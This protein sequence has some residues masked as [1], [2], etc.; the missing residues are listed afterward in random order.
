MRDRRCRLEPAHEAEAEA[1][2]ARID[3]AAAFASGHPVWSYFDE[4]QAAVGHL[5]RL[6]GGD[7]AGGAAGAQIDPDA[8]ADLSGPDA[9]GVH[10]AAAVFEDL[11][12]HDARTVDID[13]LA[14][15][16]VREGSLFA[17]GGVVRL[18]LWWQRGGLW[19]CRRNDG[20]PGKG[21]AC[22]QTGEQKIG[23]SCDHGCDHNM[24][25][26]N[27]SGMLGARRVQG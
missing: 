23:L 27:R 21:E 15:G 3:H 17:R 26:M 1:I 10:R 25:Q 5:K 11:Q 22:R 14:K 24:R 13:A 9:A 19:L 6:A 4:F 18:F 16:C 8:Q 7:L 20:A 12:R 2:G